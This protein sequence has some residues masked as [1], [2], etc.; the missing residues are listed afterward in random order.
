MDQF[1]FQALGRFGFGQSE[2]GKKAREKKDE[3]Q[4]QVQRAEALFVQFVAEHCLPF[5]TGDHFTKLVKSMFPDSEIARHFQCSRTKTSVLTRFGNGKFC[6]DQLIRKLTSD[7]PV[8][9]SLLVDES[10]DRG[11]EAKDLVVLLRFFDTSVMKAVA[12]FI[13][14]PTAND[15]R[16]SAIFAEINECLV[17]RGLRYEHLVCFNSDTCNTMKGQRNG[18][19]RYLRDKQPDVLDLGCICHLENLAVKAAMKSLPIKI[20]SL[21]VDINT[22]FY[23]SVKRKQQLKEFCTFVNVTYKK[24]LGHVETRWLSLLRVIV[25]VLEIWRALKSYFESHPDSE[26]PGR[27]KTITSLLCDNT[28]LYMLFLSF[29]LPTVNAFNIAFQATTYTTIHRLHPEMK[30][31]TKRILYYFVDGN[32][33]DTDDVR[34]T[35][36]ED[37]SFQLDDDKVE[38]GDEARQLTQNLREDGMDP[39]VDLFFHHVRHFYS[40]FVKTLINKFPFGSPILCDLRI[41]NPSERRTFKDFPAAVV[42]LAK[43][44][45]QL[46]LSGILEELKIEAIDFHMADAA[47]LPEATD[48]V[49][50]FWAALHDIKHIGS[51]TPQYANLLVLVRALLALPASN[52]DSERCFSMVWKIDSEDRSHLERST[53]ASLLSLKLNID[54]DCFDYKPP[55]DMLKLNKSAVWRYN[56]EHGSHN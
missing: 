6:H 39:E 12:R 40:T 3:Q 18:V 17:S 2:A 29:L 55:A 52:A 7:T 31:L 22:H 8:Y 28:K 51:T 5:R 37:P 35:P 43:Q 23:M 9:Y 46:G 49:D 19:V 32:V 41:L 53:V 1:P 24:I 56:Q 33:I 10:N 14:L 11:E 50:T 47:H 45:P 15:G 42:H 36:F 48:D 30:R 38:V 54:P 21:M 44:L 25:R 34:K 26:K 20:D 4:L 16:A 27:V 13:D